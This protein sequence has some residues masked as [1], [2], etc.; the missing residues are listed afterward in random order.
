LEESGLKLS[1]TIID[2]P[3]FGDNIDNEGS[4][5]AVMKYVEKQ[6]DEILSEES[7][8][9]RNP[10]FQGKLIDRA[11]RFESRYQKSLIELY[12]NHWTVVDDF[13]VIAVKA[14]SMNPN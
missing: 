4:I 7:R 6:Y 5:S 1:L 12:R 2:T 11:C 8:I 9:K 3:G 14:I 10:K 13:F